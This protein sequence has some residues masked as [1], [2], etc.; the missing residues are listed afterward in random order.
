MRVRDRLTAATATLMQRHGVAGTGI[1]EILA[2]SGVTRRSI[3]L[4]FPGGKAEL[5]AAATRAAGD[6]MTATVRGYLDDPDPI[7]AF[8]DMWG[9]VL[10]STDFEGGCPIVAAASSRD[11]SP[12]GASTAADVFAEWGQL[13][14]DR[15]RKDGINRAAAQSLST[16][17][18]AAVEG[19]VILSRAAR[20]TKPLEQVTKHLNELISQHRPAESR[21][22]RR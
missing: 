20:S 11:E 22:R 18:V 6:E 3:Y 4:N 12:E 14:A 10:V 19:A 15:L 21:G 13:L 5:V 9:E 16:T 2:T 17:I 8:A 1:A 7:G